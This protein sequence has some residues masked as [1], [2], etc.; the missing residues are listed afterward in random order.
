MARS[1][2]CAGQDTVNSEV[3]TVDRLIH[4]GQ[5]AARV[6]YKARHPTR[7]ARQKFKLSNTSFKL[8]ER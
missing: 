3:Y 2:F 6:S 4:E 5:H 7:I 8:L 1:V